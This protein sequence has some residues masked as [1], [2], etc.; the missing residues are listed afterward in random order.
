MSRTTVQSDALPAP[1]VLAV[2]DAFSLFFKAY[3]AIRSLTSQTGV[4]TNAIFGFIKMM[5][6]LLDE[7][8]PDYIAVAFDSPTPTFRKEI[9]PEYKANRPE[10]PSDLIEQIP[11]LKKTVA[12]WGMTAL[13]RDGFEADDLIG[14][15]SRRAEEAGLEVLIVSA[16]KDLF[17]LVGPRVRCMR[18]QSGQ[19]EMFG[20]KEVEAKLGVRPTQ[21]SDYLAL[22]GDASDNIPGVAKVGPKTAAQLLGQF[23]DVEALL[24][25]VESIETSRLRGLIEQGADSARLSKRLTI[26]DGSAPVEVDWK[27]MRW[28]GPMTPPALNDL[29]AELGFRSLM[30]EGPDAQAEETLPPAEE[31]ETAYTVVLTETALREL[32]GRLLQ[33]PLLAVDTETTGLDP[34]RCELV[35][36]SLSTAPGEAWYV[37]VGHRLP[38]DKGRQVGLES[39]REIL[40]PILS[41]EGIPKTAQNAKYDLKVLRQAGMDLKGLAFDSL[42]GSYLLEPGERHGLKSMT[43]RLLGVDQTPI[44][45]LIGAGKS[46]ITMAEVSIDSAADYACQDADFTLRLTERLRSRLAGEGLELVMNDIE[47]P[48][49]EILANMEIEGVRLDVGYLKGLSTEMTKR[50]EEIA[51]KIYAVAGRAFNI[52]SSRQVAQ[53]L[54]EEQGLKPGKKGKTG[55]STD[56]SVLEGLADKHPLPRLLLDYRAVEKLLSTYIDPLPELVNPQTGRLHCSF[57]QTI[58]STGRLACSDPNLQNIP[59]RTAQGRQIRRAFLPNAQGEVLL[60]ADYSQIELRVLAHLAEDQ[61]L[62]QAFANDEDIHRLTASKVFGCVPEM[63]TNQM[64]GQ[65]KVV[66]FGVLYGMSAFRLSNDLKIPRKTAQKF[67][68]EY[69]AAYPGVRVWSEKTVAEGRETGRVKTLSGRIRTVPDLT[70]PS[71]RARA[72]AERVAV[73]TP[74][75]GT[76]ADMIKLAMI[77]VDRRLRD[78]RLGA[79][80]ILQIHDELMFTT[81]AEEAGELAALVA[82][83]MEAALPLRVP[84]QVKVSTGANWAE[85]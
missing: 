33:A 6:K 59:V 28:A 70:S 16:D 65:A 24:D 67:I 9:F 47:L 39:V 38:E 56:I 55:Y 13:Q 32:A 10:P 22:V 84:V 11:W 19:T 15:M 35:G 8:Q 34:M 52:N 83:E 63:V 68:D 46:Q 1:G 4:P 17:Q 2:V 5:R 41:D 66:N 53:I 44:T 7:Q 42:L 45:D 71:A 51:R 76:A 23:E 62:I 25:N 74:V 50:L 73:N 36:L 75:Q 21:V 30:V 79:R 31:I 58:A 49:V 72:A 29:F 48:L 54:F 18:F 77:R 3:Y 37:P 64:R 40:G 85:L 60:A 20:P 61:A 69:F 81:P 80:M 78:S 57:S 82:E 26:I 14:A 43:R 12:A 27:A